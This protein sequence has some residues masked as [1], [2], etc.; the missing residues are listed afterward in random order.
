[1]QD[2][3]IWLAEARKVKEP[4]GDLL[5]YLAVKEDRQDA[6]VWLVEA[7]LRAHAKDL[8]PSSKLSKSQG[9]PRHHSPLPLEDATRSTEATEQLVYNRRSSASAIL[10]LDALTEPKS[11]SA[12][13]ES[14]GEIWRSVGSMI[15]Q[16]A[17]RKPSSTKS[18]SIMVCVHRIL[19]HLHHVGA[20]PHSIY[21]YAPAT[22]PSVLQRPPT[23]HYWSLRIM[24]VLSDAYWISTNPPR[25]SNDSMALEVYDPDDPNGARLPSIDMA[26]LMP[27]VE[28]QIWLDFVLW[29]CVEGGWITEAAE[30]VHEMWSRRVE[31]R[32]YSVIDWSTL[33]AQEAPKLPWTTRLKAAINR[34]RMR[35]HAGGASFASDDD[36]VGFLKPPERTV[37]REVVAAIVDALVNTA[38]SR[39]GTF[40]NNHSVVGKHINVCKIML[41]R[42]QLGLGS[43][44]WNSIILRMFESLSTDPDTP[45]TFLEQIVSWSPSFL[46]EPAAANSAYLS[47]SPAQTYVADPSA[48]SVG[49]LHRL[50]SDFILAGDFR[51]ALR[52]FRRLQDI[53]DANRRISL[54]SFPQMVSFDLQQVGEEAL[55]GDG[56]QH[57]APGLNVQLPANVL[58]PFLD[59]ITDVKCFDLGSWLLHSDDVDGCI[60]PPTMYSDSVLQPALIR[61][62]SAAGDRGLLDGVTQQL[63]APLPE[64]I[65]RALLHHQIKCGNWDG[66]NEIFELLRDGDGLAWDPTDVIALARVLLHD[67]KRPSF[68]SSNSPKG[69]SPLILL[70]AL[71]RGQY[72]TADDPSQPRNLLQTRMLNQI[73]RIIVSVPSGLSKELS[74][75]CNTE[76]NRISASCTISTKAFNML[77]ESV[78]ECFGVVEGKRLCQRWCL[79][80]D[81][82]VLGGTA[83]NRDIERVVKPD[84][85]TFYHVLRP[86]T[87]STLHDDKLDA[88]GLPQPADPLAVTNNGFNATPANETSVGV[89]MSLQATRL[90][91]EEE[92]SVMD[93]GIARCLEL[94]VQWKEM[95]QDLPGLAAFHQDRHNRHATDD[96]DVAKL[97]DSKVVK[98]IDRKRTAGGI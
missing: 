72:N 49:L 50:L 26:P 13:H 46:Q 68:I 73:V 40:G 32:Q 82:A 23:L 48:I 25:V 54:G 61:F 9:I 62:A 37:S 27:D 77:L 18:R 20:V 84:I 91:Q 92:Q 5:T 24:M 4:K 2:L 17:D 51:G 52:T 1:M 94:G 53:V 83:S 29:C 85:Q 87:H 64:G 76:F 3:H 36:R 31:K 79:L 95:K 7:M 66:A 88:T 39:P 44:S 34:S 47:S 80:P 67:E 56:E 96:L 90:N 59:M 70:R 42:K 57:E 69:Q 19:A 78:V 14:L 22:E 89:D 6:V 12:T 33:S 35:E 28:P 15:L 45:S 41:E 86:I 60:I 65:L 55:I 93:W 43:S 74:A 81:T 10:D 30:I 75:F 98:P 38:S 97:V 21:N 8:Q 63:K 71:L 16:A 11:R 58:A